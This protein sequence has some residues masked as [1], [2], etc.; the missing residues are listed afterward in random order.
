MVVAGRFGLIDNIIDDIIL[1]PRG[2][3]LYDRADRT[4]KDLRSKAGEDIDF[5]LFRAVLGKYQ[6]VNIFFAIAEVFEAEFRV[7]G[8]DVRSYFIRLHKA[9]MLQITLQGIDGT[10]LDA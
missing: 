9:G 3:G 7:H 10:S 8:Y 6:R 5:I 2:A 4:A 1:F